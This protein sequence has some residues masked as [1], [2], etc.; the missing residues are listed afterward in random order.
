MSSLCFS[1]VAETLGSYTDEDFEGPLSAAVGIAGD[2]DE[3]G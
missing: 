3:L 2:H 1:L